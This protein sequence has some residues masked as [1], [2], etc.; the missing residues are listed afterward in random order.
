MG[1][2]GTKAAQRKSNPGM[3]PCGGLP[4][5][6]PKIG[7][8][9]VAQMRCIKSSLYTQ[10][11]HFP[12]SFRIS[13]VVHY[14]ESIAQRLEGAATSPIIME[15]GYEPWTVEGGRGKKKE[16]N[17]SLG[18]A[19]DVLLKQYYK[20]YARRRQQGRRSDSVRLLRVYV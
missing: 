19:E 4:N 20:A 14:R 12:V 9:L 8:K 2:Q 18:R 11:V 7:T 6:N 16:E 17:Q 15:L 13:I 5:A 10:F 3:L 1:V